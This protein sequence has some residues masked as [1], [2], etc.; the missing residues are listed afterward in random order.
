MVVDLAIDTRH[1]AVQTSNDLAAALDL[2]NRLD[3]IEVEIARLESS[4]RLPAGCALD[5][6]VT[7]ASA[8]ARA[9]ELLAQRRIDASIEEIG[10]LIDESAVA[11]LRK[12]F[13]E[14]RP[15]RCR[16]DPIDCVIA[17]LAGVTAGAVDM[18]AARIPKNLR[19]NDQ[20]QRGSWITETLREHAIPADNWLARMCHVPFDRVAN[21]DG[22][23]AGLGPLTHRVHNFGH[24]PLFGLAFGTMDIMRGTMTAVGKDGVMR[25]AQTR[26]PRIAN[27][28]VA[29]GL[30]IMH[31]LSDIGTRSGIPLPGWSMLMTSNLDVR[32]RPI[33]ET[34]RQMYLRGFNSSHLLAMATVP[35]TIELIL[36][37]YWVA[38]M[39]I[40]DNYRRANDEDAAMA[41]S[42]SISDQPR[43][44]ALSL[45]ANGAG[46]TM[47]AAKVAAFGGNP[48]AIN[49]A[50]WVS[51][52][53]ALFRYTNDELL[54]PGATTD[55]LV[56]QFHVNR[57][58]LNVLWDTA[59][60]GPKDHR[61]TV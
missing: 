23:I 25:V 24:D 4:I 7:V 42:Q 60:L 38:R 19:W 12:S 28:A 6:N 5:D 39:T 31:L 59:A 33:N 56:R 3:S 35:A 11:E 18:F 61:S 22:D 32:G 45:A 40:D 9:Q 27:P 36:R 53:N 48:L 17:G 30:E 46:A 58:H 47:N 44:R 10:E 21:I 55:A 2:A 54:K 20:A 1:T 8:R 37:S 16:L 29:L 57:R 49:Y 43:F 15:L 34:A 52:A 51:F 50:Q 14:F 41:G 13:V 26:D